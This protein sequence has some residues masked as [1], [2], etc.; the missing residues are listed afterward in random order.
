[1]SHSE[2]GTKIMSQ[3]NLDLDE[4]RAKLDS[5]N[6]Q[7]LDFLSARLKLVDQV[8]EFK[9]ANGK[10]I[11]DKER[12]SALLR[13]IALGAKSRNIPVGYAML[14]FRAIIEGAVSIEKV[15]LGVQTKFLI[16]NN[17]YCIRC[18]WKTAGELDPEIDWPMC[19]NC[20]EPLLMSVEH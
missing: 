3:Q 9:K 10:E 4:I 7:F 15:R 5:L 1:M 14:V 13:K 12:E 17:Y 19:S 16:G 11:R 2:K 6:E 18:R 8:A 20:K